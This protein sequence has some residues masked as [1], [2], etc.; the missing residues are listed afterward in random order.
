MTLKSIISDFIGAY[1]ELKLKERA[2]EAKK[3]K[4]KIEK[5]EI[6]KKKLEDARKVI[7]NNELLVS[8]QTA[9]IIIRIFKIYPTDKVD[10]VIFSTDNPEYGRI[11][12]NLK[13]R[14]I[15]IC[16][17][18]LVPHLRRDVDDSWGTTQQISVRGIFYTDLFRSLIECIYDIKNPKV[19]IDRKSEEAKLFE[20]Y[21][22]DS[23]NIENLG[24]RKAI[25]DEKMLNFDGTWICHK[26]YEFYSFVLSRGKPHSLDDQYPFKNENE[27]AYINKNN[28]LF[29]SQCYERYKKHAIEEI[30]QEALNKRK[31]KREKAIKKEKNLIIQKTLLLLFTGNGAV[32]PPLI[33]NEPYLAQKVYKEL[34]KGVDSEL[35]W[36]SNRLNWPDTC[37]IYENKSSKDTIEIIYSMASYYMYQFAPPNKDHWPK[38]LDQ[39]ELKRRKEFWENRLYDD[40]YYQL[41]D[42]FKTKIS[43]LI[44]YSPP[45][46]RKGWHYINRCW[47][48]GAT[49]NSDYC[50][51]VPGFGYKCNK[52][53]RSLKSYYM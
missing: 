27:T 28:A 23:S 10:K 9:D 22:M 21:S 36:A 26:C 53:G 39:N 24:F 52:C 15:T 7:F 8:K 17:N 45:F 20:Q 1:K 25:N 2:R 6:E 32:E 38:P 16:L 31:Y 41:I 11:L 3:L 30:V 5:L 29:C 19:Q 40:E 12:N 47:R 37:V 49:I 34:L 33:I 18:N 44:N 46:K 42:K 13:E 35:I 51:E 43:R 48:C 4:E 14:T 50:E